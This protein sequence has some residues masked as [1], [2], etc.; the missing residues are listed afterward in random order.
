MRAKISKASSNSDFK[1]RDLSSPA[2]EL[3]RGYRIDV[4][5]RDDMCSRDCGSEFYDY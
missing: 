4:D 5:R 1:M 3:L 2:D